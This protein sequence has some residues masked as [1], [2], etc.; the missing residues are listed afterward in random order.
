M[1]V[2][3]LPDTMI[4]LGRKNQG[5]GLGLRD[6]RTFLHEI[7][8]WRVMVLDYRLD[9]VLESLG[10]MEGNGGV[11]D[12]DGTLF[13][14]LPQG[15]RNGLTGGACHGCHL[16]VSE[17]QRESIAAVY[18][19]ADLVS[20]F[21]KEATEAASNGFSEGDAAGVLECKAVF[22]ANALN[23]AHLGF[24][25]IAKERKETFAF[26]RTKL[27]RCQGFSRD[28]VDTV[29]EGCIKSEY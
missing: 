16:F 4:S 20:E 17:K 29:G 22:L 1:S 15:A 26:N 21:E 12:G 13:S 11:F 23:S 2:L 18:M 25:V 19:L 6:R 9:Q 10:L 24:A 3:K 5:M 7:R 27:C 14:K 28:F 8:R